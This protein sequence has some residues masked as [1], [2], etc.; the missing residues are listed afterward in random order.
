MAKKA[1]KIFFLQ[2]LKIKGCFKPYNGKRNVNIALQCGIFHHIF[3]NY[4]L[5]Q[6]DEVTLSNKPK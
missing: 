1:K 4:R 3:A 2:K 6:R 5:R